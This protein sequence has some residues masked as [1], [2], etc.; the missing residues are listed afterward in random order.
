MLVCVAPILASYA[1]YYWGWRPT[2]HNNYGTL[3]EPQREVPALQ[4]RDL[5][6]AP[7]E[8][9]EWRGRFWLFI[10]ADG[11]CARG[12]D[13]DRRLWLLRQM[14]QMLGKERERL[15]PVWLI[16]DAAMPDATL[17]QALER[18]EARRVGALPE[19]ERWL[20]GQPLQSFFVVD[21]FGHLMLRFPAE[22]EVNRT[23]AD[24][25]R[26]LSASAQ[27][28]LLQPASTPRTT[29]APANASGTTH[30]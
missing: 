13:C 23:R 27:W 7:R 9:E 1:A 16:P 10:V 15:V 21:P 17:R 30:E 25:M 18:I 4:M 12:S 8:A 22:P 14:H 5:S 24:L 2:S 6:G 28:Q 19:L 20:A 29:A 26:L 11:T 3:I